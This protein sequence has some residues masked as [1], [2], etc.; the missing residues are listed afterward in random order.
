M[1]LRFFDEQMQTL[2]LGQDP[3]RTGMV[4]LHFRITGYQTGDGRL[5]GLQLTLGDEFQQGQSL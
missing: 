2:K 3:F 4:S 1:G 5:I